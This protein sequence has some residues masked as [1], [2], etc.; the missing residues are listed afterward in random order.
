[1]RRSK[2]EDICGVEFKLVLE[3]GDAGGEGHTGSE[4][5]RKPG[6]LLYRGVKKS[7]GTGGRRK[8]RV[9]GTEGGAIDR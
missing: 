4:G 9:V 1:M 3:K 2:G 5:S 6:S 7:R 8:G